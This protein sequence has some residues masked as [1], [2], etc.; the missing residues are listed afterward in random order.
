MTNP[1]KW[2]FYLKD[3]ESPDL[4]IDW[5]FYSLI[6]AALQRRVWLYPASM[7]IYPNIF[8]LLVGPPAAGKSRVL[9]QVTDIIKSEKLM[10]PDKKKNTMVPMFPHGADT[11]TQES[12]LR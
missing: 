6:S 8:T 5:G 1:D 9:S 4:F 2:R 12:L 3:M 7:A 11:T 10:E